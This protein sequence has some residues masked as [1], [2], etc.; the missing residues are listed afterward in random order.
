MSENKSNDMGKLRALRLRLEGGGKLS[1]IEHDL[2]EKLNA[3]FALAI[4]E[5]QPTVSLAMQS[6]S[7][8]LLSAC[9]NSA[10]TPEQFMKNVYNF[11]KDFWFIQAEKYKEILIERIKENREAIKNNPNL[12][13][14][15][16]YPQKEQHLQSGMVLSGSPQEIVDRLNQLVEKYY[17]TEDCDCSVCVERRKKE[18][19]AAK[20]EPKSPTKH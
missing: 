8:M 3:K 11:M 12:V 6:L 17:P 14:D 16:L 2:I 15:K 10:D 4:Y 9:A 1:D 19:E 13:K 5:A 18:S 7:E 20:T